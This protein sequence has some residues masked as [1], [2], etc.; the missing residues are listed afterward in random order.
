MVAEA[1]AA[2]ESGEYRYAVELLMES[3]ALDPDPGVARQAAQL[4]SAVDDWPTAAEAA[5]IWLDQQPDSGQAAQVAAVAA[6][7]QG[8]LERGVNLLQARLRDPQ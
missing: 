7:R 8:Q 5:G 1:R 4:A 6:L 2:G 3:L